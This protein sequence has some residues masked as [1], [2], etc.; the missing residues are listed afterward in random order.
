MLVVAAA[1]QV[2]RYPSV[3]DPQPWYAFFVP[4]LTD[5]SESK[6][7]HM[8]IRGKVGAAA[9]RGVR[10][11]TRRAQSW[12]TLALNGMGTTRTRAGQGPGSAVV[13]SRHATDAQR[14]FVDRRLWFA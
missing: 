5:T 7:Y 13:V 3:V 10:C 12:Y 4:P 9:A 8:F 14:P 1:G 2:L 6:T 11:V